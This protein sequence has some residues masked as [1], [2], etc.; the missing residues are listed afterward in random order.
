MNRRVRGGSIPDHDAH[1]PTQRRQ[2]GSISSRR[3]GLGHQY[4]KTWGTKK[5]CAGCAESI[6]I[7]LIGHHDDRTAP[8]VGTGPCGT[9]QAES[10]I[11]AWGYLP[12]GAGMPPVPQ[13]RQK[14]CTSGIVD[15]RPGRMIMGQL[16]L[17]LA[18]RGQLS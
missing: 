7:S 11:A 16:M 10:P 14:P 8:A 2:E 3:T 4:G 12:E 15:Q 9:R 6:K 13:R 17:C 18:L 5:L 1:L